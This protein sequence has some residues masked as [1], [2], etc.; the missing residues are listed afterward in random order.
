MGLN[1]TQESALM[2]IGRTDQKL[3][4]RKHMWCFLEAKRYKYILN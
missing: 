1:G 2:K 3:C 4:N